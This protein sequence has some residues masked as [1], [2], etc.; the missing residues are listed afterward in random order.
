VAELKHAMSVYRIHGS[1]VWSGQNDNKKLEQI[2][3][4]IPAYN[5][6]FDFKFDKE[7]R[8]E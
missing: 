8:E 6:F 5:Q 3:Q 2:R 4:N 7:I 1:G